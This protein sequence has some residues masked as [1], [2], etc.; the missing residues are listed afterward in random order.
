MVV[1]RKSFIGIWG[2]IIALSIV[3]RCNSQLLFRSSGI[4]YILLFTSSCIAV[5]LNLKYFFSKPLI[6]CDV[7]FAVSLL[8][9]ISSDE[10]SKY[11]IVVCICTIFYYAI[12]NC[13]Y[14]IKYIEIPLV[15]FAILTSVVTWISFFSPTFYT[16]KILSLF[17]EGS[18]LAY[19]FLNR[20][21]YHGFTNHYSRNSYYIIVGIIMLFSSVITEKKKSRIKIILIAFLFCTE[22]LV[23]KRGPTLFLIAA[24]FI[25]YLKKEPTFASKIEKSLKFVAIGIGLFILAYFFV[26]GVSNIVNRILS[27]N[28]TDDISSS[29]FYLWGIALKLFENKPLLGNGWGSYLQAMSG[30]TFQGAH[31]DYFQFLAETGIAGLAIHLF[32]EISCLYYTGKAFKF[33]NEKKYQGTLEQ[34]WIFFSYAFQIFILLYALTGMPH[35]SYEQYGLYLMICGFSIGLYKHRNRYCE[36]EI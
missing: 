25:A 33:F 34:K 2:F 26:P 28:S 11:I 6:L 29:R 5:G 22:F 13:N 17:P 4:E 19:S 27:P 14:E 9:F 20:N 24:L 21:M 15:I 30:T 12:Q 31:N 1:K 3:A 8:L 10:L 35:Y 18:S 7:F 23:A 32:A 36:G 16:S